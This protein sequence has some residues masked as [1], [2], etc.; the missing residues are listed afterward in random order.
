MGLNS[1]VDIKKKKEIECNWVKFGK[2]RPRLGASEH[3][4]KEILVQVQRKFIQI[5]SLQPCYNT[6]KLKKINIPNTEE[7]K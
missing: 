2:H 4:H 1:Y 5:C 7:V 6:E 3:F